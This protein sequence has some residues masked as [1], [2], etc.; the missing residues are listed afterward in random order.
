M[1]EIPK[2]TPEELQAMF[3]DDLARRRKML[4]AERQKGRVWPMAAGLACGVLAG[5]AFRM[6]MDPVARPFLLSDP[7][8]S[9]L[10]L[11]CAAGVLAIL[12][13]LGV[14]V[15]NRENTILRDFSVS[16]FGMALALILLR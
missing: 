5:Q 7:K 12:V 2:Y 1:D 3:E 16:G 9:G 15:W 4:E 10:F 6:A 8:W 11:F 13:A 14:Y